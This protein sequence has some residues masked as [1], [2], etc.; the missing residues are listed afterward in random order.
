MLQLYY[1]KINDMLAQSTPLTDRKIVVDWYLRQY[2]SRSEDDG[3]LVIH[4]PSI[5]IE[6]MPIQWRTL[7]QNVQRAILTFR[8]HIVTESTHVDKRSFILMDLTGDNNNDHLL[9]REECYKALMNKRASLPVP[10]H[11]IGQYGV[12]DENSVLM[13]SLVRIASPIVTDMIGNLVVSV[14]EFQCVVT[15]YTAMPVKVS[16]ENVDLETNCEMDIPKA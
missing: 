3:G 9:I 1:Y 15:D 16:V 10:A 11:L 14:E 2:H 8:L 6:F 12:H 5:F 13:E 7:P 4:T